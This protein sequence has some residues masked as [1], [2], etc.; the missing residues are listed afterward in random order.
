MVKKSSRNKMKNTFL[1]AEAEETEAFA[2]SEASYEAA[3]AELLTMPSCGRR[4]KR[5]KEL[6]WHAFDVR[7]YI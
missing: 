4:S 2:N 7:V 1:K 3:V 6:N 5:R